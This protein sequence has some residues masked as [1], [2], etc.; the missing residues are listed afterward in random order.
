MFS[1]KNFEHTTK[2]KLIQILFYEKIFDLADL[3]RDES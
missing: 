1:N 3:I 2:T